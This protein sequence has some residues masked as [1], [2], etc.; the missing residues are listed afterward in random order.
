MANCNL[1]IS[2]TAFS[3]ALEK[4][5]GNSKTL[6]TKYW[7]AIQGKHFN[8]FEEYCKDKLN[9]TL[10]KDGSKISGKFIDSVIKF[11]NYKWSSVNATSK[12]QNDSTLV[13][14]FGYSSISARTKGIKH[15]VGFAK[16]AYNSIVALSSKKLDE[17]VKEYGYDNKN[18]FIADSIKAKAED[19]IAK[20]FSNDV[21]SEDDIYDILDNGDI[22]E[23]RNLLGEE[24]NIQDLNLLA[25]YQE[26]ISNRQDFFDTVFKHPEL[27][28][29]RLNADNLLN[30]TT[31]EDKTSETLESQEDEDVTDSQGEETNNDN[32]D[33]KDNSIAELNEK[34]GLYT[35]FLS[36]IDS[37]VKAYLGS[38]KK[39]NSINFIN[40][41]PDYAVDEEFGIANTMDAN[42]CCA[43][44]YSMGRYDNVDIM[45]NRIDELANTLPDFVEFHTFANYLRENRDF[46]YK[47]YTTF[48]KAIISKME[49]VVDGG[50]GSTI[51][52]NRRS[53]TVTALRFEYLNSIK[54]TA[55]SIEPDYAKDL[56]K[57]IKDNIDRIAEEYNTMNSIEDDDTFDVAKKL[58][59][60]DEIDSDINEMKVNIVKLL[61][62][63]YPTI[64]SSGIANY[65]EN[66]NNR[67]KFENIKILADLL[68]NTIKGAAETHEN[69][70]SKI[71]VL[72]KAK[73]HNENLRNKRELGEAVKDE[74]FEDLTK[75]YIKDYVSQKSQATAFQLAN[76]LAKYTIVKIELN[77]VNV[78]GKQSSCV[79]NDSFLTN[80]MNT[81]KSDRALENYGKYKSGSRQ[82]DF[83][84]I[85]IEHWDYEKDENG[86]YKLDKDNNPIKIGTAPINYGLFTQNPISKELTPTSYAKDLLRVR[87]FD[88]ATDTIT[89]SNIL[90][91]EMS[92][93]DYIATS[94]INFFNTTE[95]YNSTTFKG[96]LAN[97]FMRTPS[98][99]PKNFIIKAPKYKV[100]TKLGDSNSIFDYENKVEARKQIKEKLSEIRILS[101]EE[102]DEYN[103]FSENN[104]KVS[105]SQLVKHLTNKEVSRIQIQ[106]KNLINGAKAKPGDIVSIN[107][108][109][110]SEGIDN[111]YVIQG[112]FTE[113]DGRLY[114]TDGS[115]LGMYPSRSLDVE[116][117]LESHYEK[118]LIKEGK[119][120]R[121]VNINHPIFKQYK[122]SFIQELTD[123][124]NA[125]DKIF[126]TK[127]GK[128][129]LEINEETGLENPVFKPG[130]D[131][132]VNGSRK[133]YAVY[134]RKGKTIL[135]YDKSGIAKLTGAV[136]GS[137][138]FL[139]LSNDENGKATVRNY[140]QELFDEQFNLL[141][142]AADN[143]YIHTKQV[144]NGVE[145]ELT[146]VQEQAINDKIS[147][148]IIDYIDNTDARL[149]QY[150][151]LIPENLVSDSNIAEFALNYYSTYISFGDLFEGDTKFYKSTQDFLKRAKEVQGSGVPY[152]LVNYEEEL[153]ATKHEVESVLNKKEFVRTLPNGT[154][155]PVNIKQYT[156]FTGVTIKNTV[157]TGETIGV[158]KKDSKG[159]IIK[160][161]KGIPQFEKKGKLTEKLE[162]VL[163]TESGYTKQQ[164]ADKA[165]I[166]M[167]G[168]D[169]TTVNDAQSYITFEEWVRRISARGQLEEY[170]PIIEAVLDESKPLDAQTIQRFIQVQ[171]NFY[172][173]QYYNAELGIIAPRQIKNAEFVLVPR[174]IAGT[175]LENVY[176]L[177]NE[178]GIDQ[179]NTEETSKAGK[180]NVLTLWNDN[181]ELTQ[182]AIDDFRGNAIAASELFNYNYLYTQ[183]ETKQH[184][185]S[186]NKAAIQFV[187][188]I[189]DNIP[190]DSELYPL[191]K[192]FNKLYC[193][194]I[195]ESFETLMNELNVELDE[196]G[197]VV[198][199][200]QG[201]VKN[202]NFTRFYELLRGEISRLGLD[203]NY[204]DYTEFNDT[205]NAD[206]SESNTNIGRNTKM[207]ADMSNVSS[208]LESIAQS[209]FNSVVTR[210]KFP[211]FHAAQITNI[212]FKAGT[213]KVIYKLNQ[214]G[215]GRN[216]TDNLSEE[217]YNKLPQKNK[218]YYNRSK[219]NIQAS[220]ELKYHPGGEN[221]IEIMLPKS[222]FGLTGTDE[223]ALKQLQD[224]KLDTIIGYRIPTEGKQSIC[225]MKV[226]GF[227]DDAYGSTIVVPDDWVSQTGSDFDID[228][229][230]GF[231]FSYI[232]D[233]QNKVHKVKYNEKAELYDW[234]RYV[235]REIDKKLNTNVK[236][237][238]SKVGEEVSDMMTSAFESIHLEESEAY[239]ALPQEYKDIIKDI[240][241]SVSK[242]EKNKKVRYINQLNA[243]SNRIQEELNKEDISEDVKQKLEDYNE[244]VDYIIDL[245]NNQQDYYRVNVSDKIKLILEK[246]QDSFEKEAKKYGLLSFE[247]YSKL[248]A[249]KRNS[250]K[251]RTNEM[252]Q[253]MIDILSDDASLEEN[254]SRSQ[255]DDIIEARDEIIDENVSIQRNNRS[256]FNFLDQAEFQDDTMSGAKL[257][258]FSVTR[259]TFCSVCNTVRPSLNGTNIIKVIY[260]AADGYSFTELKKSFDKVNK[261]DD[262]TFVVEHDTFG[263]SKNNRN[264]VGE[265]ITRYSS[266]TTAHILDAVKKGMVPNVNDFTFQ[267][268]KLFPDIGSDYRTGIAFMMQPGITRIVDAYN[269]N[270][271]IYAKGYKD[272]VNAAIRS[273]AKE[274][275]GKEYNDKLG[276][277]EVIVK[278]DEKYSKQVGKI[279]LD[280]KEISTW[281]IDYTALKDRI[282]NE[283]EFENTSPVEERTLLFDLKVILQY[284][285]LSHL[286]S[287]ISNYARV[288]NPDK[289]GAKQ[290]IFDTNDVFERIEEILES[291]QEALIVNTENGTK[292][293]LTTIYPDINDGLNGYLTS[294]NNNSEYPTLHNFLKYSSAISI[295]VN[296]NLFV[297][298]QQ[299]FVDT[300]NM[301]KEAFSGNN[302][303]LDKD[304]YNAFKNYIIAYVY[305]Q[306]DCLKDVCVYTK[307][308]GLSSRQT[309]NTNDE[310]ERIYG[311]S[312]D[313]DLLVIDKEG[314]E[315]QFNPDDKTN[316]TED[317]INQFAQL[318]PA[319]KIVWIQSNFEEKGIFGFIRA[320]LFNDRQS[321]YNRSGSQTLEYI[322]NLSD[323]ETVY[324]EFE[325]AFFN[326]NPLVA[327]A[328]M[329]IIKYAFV[330]EGFKMKRNGISKIIKNTA[331]YKTSEEG[332]TGIAD[333]FRYH[334]SNIA[335][336]PLDIDN[337]ITNFVRSNSSMK[338]IRTVYVKKDRKGY[339]LAKKADGIIYIADTNNK[340]KEFA[341]KYGVIYEDSNGIIQ[342]NKFVKLRFD[343]ELTLYKINV[344]ASTGEVILSPLNILENNENATWSVNKDN[345]LYLEDDYYKEYVDALWSAD[346]TSTSVFNTVS[347]ELSD[348]KDKYK[349][350][351]KI[352]KSATYKTDFDIM[353]PDANHVGGF[354]RIVEAVKNHFNE[355]INE[356]LFIRSLALRDYI[357]KSGEI[358]A[359]I[360]TIDDTDYLIQ[361]VEFEKYNKAYLSQKNINK[362]IKVSNPQIKKL[363]EQ[364][365][366]SNPVHGIN[367]CYVIQKITQID[368]SEVVKHSSRD[369]VG[370][371]MY[372]AIR[373]EAKNG[374]IEAGKQLKRL[375]DKEIIGSKESAMENFNEIVS[376]N[377][378]YVIT[379]VDKLLDDLK[380][381]THDEEGNLIS[382]D[383]PKTIDIIRNNR[384]E[385]DR[386]LKLILDS[387]AFVRNY[388]LINEFDI[389]S[390]D[391]D[392][393]INLNKIKNKINQLSVA[394]SIAKAE[395][396]FGEEYLSKLSDNP[397][398]Q[399]QLQG[400]FDGFHSAGV[401]DA[402]VNDLQETSSPLL[403]IVTKEVMADIR[404]KELAAGK[405]IQELRD[406][407][408]DIKLRAKAKGVKINW[409][410]IV[411]S[412]GEF[413][414]AYTDDFINDLDQ[415]RNA[416]RSA[417]VEYGIGSLPYLKAKFEYD[418]WK[419]N[420]VHRELNDSYY[421]RKLMLD[422]DMI[423]NFPSVFEAYSKLDARRR[424]I[425]SHSVNGVL[426]ETYQEE[427]KDIKQQISDLTALAVY[428]Q[429]TN[430]FINK[431][432][433]TDPDNRFRGNP[434]YTL[435][436]A[437]ALTKYI[438]K[439]RE[440]RD[441][442]YTSDTKYGFEEELE[443]HLD[444]I[445]NYELRD[446]RGNITVPMSELMKHEDYVKAKEWVEHNAR[447]V[448][449]EELKDLLNDAFAALKEKKEGRSVL[450]RYAIKHDA[451][452]SH[453][454]VDARKFTDE[455]IEKI[456]TDELVTYNIREG[457]PFSE[458]NLITNAP[459]DD[460]VFNMDFYKGFAREDAKNPVYIA[461]VNKI[462][463][464]LSRYYNVSTKTVETSE[465][466][467]EELKE[468]EALYDELDTTQKYIT[469]KD[470]KKVYTHI[471][472]NVE[473]ITN[474]S[475]FSEQEALAKNNGDNYYRVWRR[476]NMRLYQD[477]AG[478][479][480]E[481][482]VHYLYS[483]C[484]PKGYK[485]DGTG[486]NSKVDKKKTDAL[487]TIHNY[488]NFVKTEY[489]YDKFKEMRAKSDE[490]F[491][492]WYEANHIYNPYTHSYQ[493]LQCWTRIEYID[494][495][496]DGT[497]VI[498]GS[499]IPAFS[500]R[501][502]RP[503]NGKD[504]NGNPNGDEDKTNGEFKA[505]LGYRHNYKE[506]TSAY[507]YGTT[508]YSDGVDYKNTTSMN[509]FEEEL[510]EYVQNL[511]LS[512]AHTESARNYFA[513][514]RMPSRAKHQK[515]DAKF[516]GKEALKLIGWVE[517][518]IN[519]DLKSDID[520]A[521]D[522]VPTMPMTEQLKSKD[523][524]SI[525][526]NQPKLKDYPDTE[527][528]KAQYNKDLDEYNKNRK[529]A[530]EKNAKIHEELIDTQWEAVLEDFIQKA[531]HYNAVQDNKYMLFY[532]KQM[533][534]KLDVYV[535]ETGSN[536]LKRNDYNSID[537]FDTYE[538]KKDTNLSKQY[539]NWIRRLVYDQWKE[540]GKLTRAA[541]LLQGLT[542]AKFM[543][544]NV[545]GGLANITV[546]ETNVMMEAIA[547]EYFGKKAWLKGLHTVNAAIPSALANLYSDKAT[548]VEDAIIK[549]MNIVDFD[550]QRGVVHVA[551]AEEKLQRIRNAAYSPQT[552]GEYIMQNGAMFSM[553]YSHRLYTNHVTID[554]ESLEG[555]EASKVNGKLSYTFKNEA[556]VIRDA[557]EQALQS[558]L[559]DELRKKW[560]AFNDYIK[561]D[562]NKLKD[563][564]WFRKDFTTEFANI[565][566]NEEQLKKYVET[567]KKLEEEAKK[568]FNDDKKHPTLFSQCALKDGTFAFK[569]DSILANLGDEAYQIMGRF[570][571][572][573]ISVNKKIHGVYDRLG[574]AEWESHWYGGPI[575]QY[576]KHIYPGIMKHYRR[577][578]Y[579]N[580]ERGTVEK[581]IFAS[582]KDFLALPLHKQKFIKE[583]KANTGISDAELETTQ[584]IQN[585]FKEYINFIINIK[586]TWNTLPEYDKANIARGFAEMCGVLA[587]VCC[588]IALRAICDDD[589]EQTFVYNFFMYEAD[590]LVSEAAM[591]H[592]WGAVSEVK[593]LYSSPVAIQ[594]GLEDF[595]SSMGFVAQ[596]L[597]QGE[598][599]NPDYQSGAYAGENKLWVMLRRQVPIYHQII[600]LQRLQRNN[601]YY[602]L[603]DNMLS[604][605][606]VKDIADWINE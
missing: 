526:Y 227:V 21:I 38:L 237:S 73:K 414:Q 496:D 604:I 267:V 350:K 179:L 440:L 521:T 479:Y 57:N 334:I 436:S 234:F 446:T 297:T 520:Y 172:Y 189:V 605:I 269:A 108:N 242:S 550:E 81:L 562:P 85:L 89:D 299:G 175:E 84:N 474:D 194:N 449:D 371:G 163:H 500:Q 39:L 232:K 601:H 223:E 349:F 482:P 254:L 291:T 249:S 12:I 180:G 473:F 445:S 413:I 45:I 112:T 286:G 162:K 326:D 405:R 335:N 23:L 7:L 552:S 205:L 215:I 354:N 76:E 458:R 332:G 165:A 224:E 603:G 480:V 557:Y 241:K 174:L 548:S 325:K 602:K 46:A 329:D 158:F 44:L 304:T 231:T 383:N 141:Y 270:K 185:D 202:L 593:K 49:T 471:K 598:D 511:L 355:N 16:N 136:F 486:N 138:R 235:N 585:L 399:K 176:N 238:I 128:V 396:Q 504:K 328:T 527:E 145:V 292:S 589:D 415:H 90:Y 382:I 100:T 469:K 104:V 97:Y 578:G 555:K 475:K 592:P 200:E 153:D 385:R 540:S 596:Y 307:E 169:S 63:Y 268:Y 365:R 454:V 420:H 62:Y 532:A 457:Q 184:I 61:Q 168:Y 559:T 582:I 300:I 394:S 322:E 86:N 26:I 606:P 301:L 167:A 537:G 5:F 508:N 402:F 587:G 410:H 214:A 423:T 438:S 257:K 373:R 538:T 586:L 109:Y 75:Y 263:W 30:I 522:E 94:F 114:I 218:M 498:E 186:E 393:R 549:F 53:D 435:E 447:Y 545:T 336:G 344:N 116:Q 553:M 564:L 372:R 60:F 20:R 217:E 181:G 443:K 345:N 68:D 460:T 359:S 148:F 47:V 450:S 144:A 159:N 331:L 584:G 386:Y 515:V 78:H 177:M 352:A 283:G 14:R 566:L 391:E 375:K 576:H 506:K 467:I 96:S 600:M 64:T 121:K 462:N 324:D 117:A 310:I 124:A 303:R 528:G 535:K 6:F 406:K 489:Y 516:L 106:K 17:A 284:N 492:A 518:N 353:K 71:A 156:R 285:K 80:L 411:K 434:A 225:V 430:S 362:E 35:S 311:Y 461:T 381:F 92:K 83:S 579:F 221:Y 572:R 260:R 247:E 455:E 497:H 197:N 348:K 282:K 98:D 433:G 448:I 70:I 368:K 25:M 27:V 493:P 466:S 573:V 404:A 287:A 501:D 246:R 439:I 67:D 77:S 103:D 42:Q 173:D 340:D 166:M 13:G 171:K 571:G 403:Q 204:Y 133:T 312:K 588:A 41:E 264:V 428:D 251:A 563:Y 170:M 110:E 377:A 151:E 9:Y 400:I 54:H 401:F 487:R 525:N 577:V 120:A 488:C 570:K 546:G 118:Q 142:G 296:R 390:E 318:S 243:V 134:H 140:G 594:N 574:A 425:Y 376:V 495:S 499:W 374:D 201:N 392:T 590:R 123:A 484:V 431:T 48:A 384:K 560:K 245:L 565:Y 370:M 137:D 567:R 210:Q 554:R 360:Q 193:E 513:K 507:T 113:E 378:E 152:G 347:N 190:K 266:E 512:L 102:I 305:R 339:E 366:E 298:Q 387:R 398:I 87:L 478:N 66:A 388:Q 452:D 494:R 294:T 523:S 207:P 308:F 293:F 187:K 483:Y 122:Q 338:Q 276:L 154:K 575:M 199:D 451:Y 203:S 271:S 505:G 599:F 289:F 583:L 29:L 503:R 417:E 182:E 127:N 55:N 395:K 490:E 135:E 126:Y 239:D 543:M 591:Y 309:E 369:E 418:K 93:G 72:A 580:E 361:K 164:A 323:I 11:Y 228:S 315:I 115:V 275:L 531:A 419:L 509:P 248:D 319:Q 229:V 416:V 101:N 32:E 437:L 160:N 8:E 597:I 429:A 99:A 31:D 539:A 468:L 316:P 278:L 191:K 541:N 313:A 1:K 265:L 397:N 105:L 569:D 149:E 547:S 510:S 407:I 10:P 444:T 131:N 472:N 380:Y 302:K 367:D 82:Y 259:D 255:F 216:L 147:E 132:T 530:E 213:G 317:E 212:G 529:E 542:S 502:S 28:D 258:A 519:G 477:E 240:H 178:L 43:I 491:N 320:T 129:E 514:G 412:N 321:K 279:T 211:G 51:I 427:L 280:D 463:K 262:N 161:S 524:V 256:P 244:V 146:E 233:K 442:Y 15:A 253:C 79:I 358:N 272:P 220:K 139:L 465:M 357:T 52:S 188:K 314:N 337:L 236:D 536:K 274:L 306:I 125:L 74:E 40:G 534:D 226:V 37:P 421:H 222:A 50:I 595:I 432:S 34:S 470:G 69:Y 581:G 273:I 485:A 24:P 389:S 343:N 250:K 441:E 143:T 556:E 59:I 19:Y 295:K 533:I 209:V 544:L 230:Y 330:V 333:S 422:D 342:Y 290:T 379:S 196:N 517:G 456:K 424:E 192:K 277:Q 341:E 551:D 459:E 36:H 157:R 91:S 107:C 327:M 464:L 95:D 3:N 195:H 356:H 409:N 2:R 22:N 150:K 130:F 252:L 56:L 58:D 561:K 155:I 476:T 351:P 18:E 198:L 4:K 363:I 426:S 183:Q 33:T 453:G 65:I 261:I 119:I 568:E 111:T 88:G 346:R 408:K 558:V 364:A 481:Q 206:N 281:A 288:C 208:K 219:G